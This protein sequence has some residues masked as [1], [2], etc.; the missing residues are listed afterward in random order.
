ME[1]YV[2][3]YWYSKYL[4]TCTENTARRSSQVLWLCAARRAQ[5]ENRKPHRA[6]C[7]RKKIERVFFFIFETL[8]SV[9]AQRP[10]RPEMQRKAVRQ[11]ACFSTKL[12]ASAVFTLTGSIFSQLVKPAAKP[13]FEFL[14]F[15][16]YFLYI[17]PGAY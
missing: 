2:P 5:P 15:S 11:N 8:S 7:R 10:A 12:C 14:T 17:P 13:T 16:C 3:V 1:K 4:G 6:P 9:G